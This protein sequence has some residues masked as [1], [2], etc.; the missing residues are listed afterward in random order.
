MRACC[1]CRR[2]GAI[3]TTMLP[4][5]EQVVLHALAK[6]PKARFVRVQD[7][8]LALEDVSQHAISLTARFPTGPIEASNIWGVL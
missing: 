1:R 7:F 8:A 2:K 3:R 6:D 4:E 5:I